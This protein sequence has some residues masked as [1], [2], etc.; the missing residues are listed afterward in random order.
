MDSGEVIPALNEGWTFFGANI[1]EWMTGV[2]ASMIF[3]E[4]CTTTPGAS[5]PFII[6][7]AVT[8]P[9]IVSG[10]RKLYPDE[11]RG[12]RNSC[13]VTLG[14]APPGI[15][16]PSELQSIWSGCPIVG[17]EKEKEFMQLGI[18]EM[19]NFKEEADENKFN[20]FQ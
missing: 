4:V 11:E 19:L 13:M 2:M 18:D 7:I 17:L 8:V 5:M 16:R 9:Y 6:A 14:F 10:L 3:M 15:P 1:F 20:L 12:L